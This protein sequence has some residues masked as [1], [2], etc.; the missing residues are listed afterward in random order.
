MFKF[1]LNLVIINFIIK[2]YITMNC[3][4]FRNCEIKRPNQNVSLSKDMSI[5]TSVMKSR[6]FLYSAVN[7]EQVQQMVQ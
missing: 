7:F 5:M 2:D 6:I 4:F 1:L 3:F